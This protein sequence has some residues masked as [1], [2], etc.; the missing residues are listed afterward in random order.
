MPQLSVP[1]RARA[2]GATQRRSVNGSRSEGG[3]AEGEARVAFYERGGC[4]RRVCRDGPCPTSRAA[5]LISSLCFS[6]CS[7]AAAFSTRAIN[8]LTTCLTS[9]ATCRFSLSH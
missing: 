2:N 1:W 6:R 4:A 9:T 3:R 5:R 8:R 7:R